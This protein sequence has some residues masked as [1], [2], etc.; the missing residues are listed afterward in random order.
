MFC[1][2][3]LFLFVNP[4]THALLRKASL[5]VGARGANLNRVADLMRKV[6]NPAGFLAIG[7]CT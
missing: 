3:P 6:A 2:L 7:N 1:G 5:S 4:A